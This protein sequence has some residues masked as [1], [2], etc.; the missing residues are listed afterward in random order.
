MEK[1]IVG[2]KFTADYEGNVTSLAC[3]FPIIKETD[4]MV[5]PDVRGTT[6]ESRATIKYLSQMRK[7]DL[8]HVEG[9]TYST[10]FSY[11]AHDVVENHEQLNI[12]ISKVKSKM[13][14]EL[15][16][17]I[18]LT[19]KWKESYDRDSG[20]MTHEIPSETTSEEG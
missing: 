20:G 3:S 6:S 17:R 12:L 18:S 13:E 4:K 15:L 11:F 2:V 9:D 8:G 10:Y 1:V 19:S 14:E 5:Y 16:R 7:V